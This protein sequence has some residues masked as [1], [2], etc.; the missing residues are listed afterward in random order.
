MLSLCVL[1]LAGSAALSAAQAGVM[2][3]TVA[4]AA[5]AAIAIEVFMV[6]GLLP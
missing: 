1:S 2:A 6:A 5:S 4:V 3:R